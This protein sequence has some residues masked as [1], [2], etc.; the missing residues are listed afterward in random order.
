MII[1]FHFQLEDYNYIHFAQEKFNTYSGGR[2][3]IYFIQFSDSQILQ[4]QSQNISDY[5]YP[6]NGFGYLNIGSKQNYS[7]SRQ[8]L[9][10]QFR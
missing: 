1:P 10:F 8:Q 4:V 2:S 6:D 9:Q 7:N 5:F 3:K